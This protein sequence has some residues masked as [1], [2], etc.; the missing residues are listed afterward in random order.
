MSMLWVEGLRY[1]K[2]KWRAQAHV[3]R[4]WQSQD[5]NPQTALLVL[6]RLPF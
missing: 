2:S 4:E 1:P 5:L 6:S 3:K